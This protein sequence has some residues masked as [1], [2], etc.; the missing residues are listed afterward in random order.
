MSWAAFLSGL[1]GATFLA[2][3]FDTMLPLGATLDIVCDLAGIAAAVIFF[4]LVDGT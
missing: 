3:G 2:L 1:G 4:G